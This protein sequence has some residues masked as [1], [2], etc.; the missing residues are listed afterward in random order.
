MEKDE[1]RAVTRDIIEFYTGISEQTYTAD[2][3]IRVQQ[4]EIIRVYGAWK[5]IA[6][7]WP[8]QYVTGRAYWMDSWFQVTPDVLIPRPETEELVLLVESRLKKYP[9][10]HILD[11]GTGS[12]IIP[13]YLA[14]KFPESQVGSTDFSAAALQV[15]RENAARQQVS[16]TFWEQDFL[17]KTTW[18]VF[19]PLHVLVSNPPYIHRSEASGMTNS[20][21]NFEPHQALFPPGDD[22]LI[23]YRRI[24][25]L[26]E[27]HRHTLQGI[28]LELN[29]LH[30]DAIYGIFQSRNF[31][32]QLHTDLSGK[33]RFYSYTQELHV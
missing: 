4:S 10:E 20:V 18:N 19:P 31:V 6:D 16:V 23:F 21:L 29:P 27:I 33:V 32:G 26:A 24:A 8:L 13:V 7:G 14:R 11:I 2:P 1:V 17:D 5:K 28:F 12:G 9:A 22:V 3:G 30:A 15:A 25:E